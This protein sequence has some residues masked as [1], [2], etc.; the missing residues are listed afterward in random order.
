MSQDQLI[1]TALAG[2]LADI[3]V[4]NGYRTDAGLRVDADERSPNEDE[5][6]FPRLTWT[7][8]SEEV[9]QPVLETDAPLPDRMQIQIV[10]TVVGF[11]RVETGE[12]P[13]DV[14]RVLCADIKQAVIRASDKRLGGL[15]MDPVR[16]L[17]RI[18]E[19]PEPGRLLVSVEARFGAR[20]MEQA[21]DPDAQ[22]T[23]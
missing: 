13:G 21:G 19:R 3:T 16:Y 12:S 20:Y 14:A 10:F 15:L 23:Q 2:R 7:D 22:L 11:D 17:G 5:D 6:V 18:I 1:V 9:I 8:R 4:A